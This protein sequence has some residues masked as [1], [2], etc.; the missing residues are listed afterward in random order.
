MQMGLF[1]RPVRIAGVA[2][3]ESIVF[4]LA[5]VEKTMVI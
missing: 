1:Q 4:F 2:A 3:S 5:R